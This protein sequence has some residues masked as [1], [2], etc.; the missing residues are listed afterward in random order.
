VKRIILVLGFLVGS[1]ILWAQNA[2]SILGKWKNLD[3]EKAMQMEIYLAQDGKY[4][5]KIINDNSQ[6]SK[7][8]NI[9]LKALQYDAKK[10]TYKGT[11]SPP[12]AKTEINVTLSLQDN[13]KLK[14]VGKKF[15]MSKTF[16]LQRIQ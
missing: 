14:M 5:G 4:Y 10:G 13:N 3:A 7:N 6:P 1:H 12:D 8:G 11:M 9:A 15:F 2:N 16:Y